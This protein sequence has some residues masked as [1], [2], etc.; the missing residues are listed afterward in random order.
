MAKDLMILEK[1]MTLG[2]K[3]NKEVKIDTCRGEFTLS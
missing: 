1:K 2:L 3:G